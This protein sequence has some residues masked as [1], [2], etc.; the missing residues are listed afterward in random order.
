MSSKGLHVLIT[1]LITSA[2]VA[3][4]LS[5]TGCQSSTRAEGSGLGTSAAGSK[6]T[7]TAPPRTGGT[8]TSAGTSR[9]AIE[10]FAVPGAFGVATGEGAVWVT[11]RT[12]ELVKLTPDGRV[13][14]SVPINQGGSTNGEA[15]LVAVG[16]GSVWATNPAENA[17]YRVD[18]TSLQVTARIQVGPDPWGV[19]VGAGH[20]WVAIHHG[21][22]HGALE[23]IDPK[24]NRVDGRVP[25]GPA[26]QGP[27]HVT[28][29]R[30]AVWVAVDGDN[31]VARVDPVTLE[32]TN[33]IPVKGAC[34]SITAVGRAVW[35]S[36]RICGSGVTRIDTDK[37][38]A[39]RVVG[40]D[41]LTL[42]VAADA[43]SVWVASALNAHLALLVRV[44]ADA[45]KVRDRLA[46]DH[47]LAGVALGFGSVWAAGGEHVV[48]VT[49]R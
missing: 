33:R 26:H 34:G 6:P 3:A 12:Q 45:Q 40:L 20:T 31:V 41:G 18:P 25:F 43:H 38:V 36:G 42:G 8:T 22:E 19:A 35:I 5:M 32:V 47:G 10:E 49:P 29:T 14:G 30:D 17:V 27:G 16:E 15:Y 48:R 39:G 11:T 7:S 13:V 24:T 21:T 28:T 9:F 44:D 1:T 4:C 23:R 37:R 2:A 46:F